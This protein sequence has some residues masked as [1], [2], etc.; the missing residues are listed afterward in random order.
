VGLD[1][2]ARGGSELK[3][4]NGDSERDDASE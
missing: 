2:G 1:D 4:G 3:P